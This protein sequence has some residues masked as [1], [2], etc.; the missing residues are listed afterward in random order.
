MPSKKHSTSSGRRSN[1]ALNNTSMKRDQAKLNAL[2][3]LR[4]FEDI[5]VEVDHLQPHIYAAC[6]NFIY[7]LLLYFS[8]FILSFSELTLSNLTHSDNYAESSDE[9][10]FSYLLLLAIPSYIIVEIIQNKVF[11]YIIQRVDKSIAI[12][13]HSKQKTGTMDAHK[14]IYTTEQ[15]ENHI[16]FTFT[17]KTLKLVPDE[18]S[19]AV[20]K[21]ENNII[22]LYGIAFGSMLFTLFTHCILIMLGIGGRAEEAS[23][24]R[25]LLSSF[26]LMDSMMR[27]CISEVSCSLNESNNDQVSKIQEQ[28]ITYLARIKYISDNENISDNEIKFDDSKNNRLYFMLPKKDIDIKKDR[29]L[30]YTMKVFFNTIVEFESDTMWYFLCK[31]TN[32][33]EE[34]ELDTAIKFYNEKRVYIDNFNI[35]QLKKIE[36]GVVTP[37]NAK[38]EDYKLI[39]HTDYYFKFENTE[40]F[41]NILLFLTPTVAKSQDIINQIQGLIKNWLSDY[42]TITVEDSLII[43]SYAST[44]NNIVKKDISDREF[45]ST[46]NKLNNLVNSVRTPVTSI[47]PIN[48]LESVT[49]STASNKSSDSTV[50][51]RSKTKSNLMK[52]TTEIARNEVSEESLLI[53]NI[54]S[55][56]K[57]P[58]LAQNTKNTRLVGNKLLIWDEKKLDKHQNHIP[59]FSYCVSKFKKIFFEWDILPPKSKNKQGIKSYSKN[60]DTRMSIKKKGKEGYLRVDAGTPEKVNVVYSNSGTYEI[61]V[62]DRVRKKR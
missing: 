16:K 39:S 53:Q 58:I 40:L 19:I 23:I 35:N 15:L 9:G 60:I 29:L 10:F 1:K 36:E 22:S 28:I 52:N 32:K 46:I 5:L 14:D 11:D 43:I 54:L 31:L 59:A 20:K 33:I 51:K 42:V 56:S 48:K 21:Y 18:I 13:N 25:L 6:F 37:I 34:N 17:D 57:N 44:L 30:K 49:E 2:K 50:R 41:V 38:V 12:S 24:E 8:Y 61:I 62:F 45:S 3:E 4:L 55:N 47:N 7:L 27:V 26:S